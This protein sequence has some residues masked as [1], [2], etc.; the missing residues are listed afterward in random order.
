VEVH[1]GIYWYSTD[2]RIA[3]N[4]TAVPVERVR[5]IQHLNKK[6]IKPDGLLAGSR[7]DNLSKGNDLLLQ[8]SG[9]TRFET[10]SNPK[11]GRSRR[12]PFHRR[13]DK[14]QD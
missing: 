14:D 11:K 3:V 13:N 8:N 9:L 5:E 7:N 4:L 2:P 1:T 10:K 12:R 6:G